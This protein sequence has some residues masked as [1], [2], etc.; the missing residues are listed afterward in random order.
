VGNRRALIALAAAGL[1]AATGLVDAARAVKPGTPGRIAFLTGTGDIA[2]VAG[3]GSGAVHVL[4]STGDYNS[5]PSWSP[6]GRAMVAHRHDAVAG[7]VDGLWVI[8]I[9]EGINAGTP[10]QIYA[11]TFVVSQDPAWAPDGSRVAFT[12][13]TTD[14]VFAVDA[15]GGGG[16]TQ[17]AATLGGALADDPAWSPDGSQIAFVERA[18]GGVNPIEVQSVGAGFAT[19]VTALNA[20]VRNSPTWSPDGTRIAFDQGPGGSLSYITLGNQSETLVLSGATNPAWSPDGSRFAA[21]DGGQIVTTPIGGGTLTILSDIPAG[22]T[23]PDWE[24]VAAPPPPPPPPPQVGP[25][26]SL[27][28]AGINFGDQK[29]G[30]KSEK[31]FVTLRNTGG[32]TLKISK[33][34]VSGD[35]AI[36]S[37]TNTCPAKLTP[38]SSCEFGATFKPKSKGRRWG[39]V[40]VF[41]DAPDS[42]Q[43]V[44]LTGKGKKK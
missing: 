8:P 23:Q 28:P 29:V 22:S 9:L 25:E 31:Q 20:E 6:D 19:A 24:S 39:V 11:D 40:K 15:G 35:F 17:I 42:P 30:K 27:S 43:R 1:L 2:F 41:D 7:G 21:D 12:S 44:E 36:S 34:Y 10:F 14:G 26:V 4:T 38:G 33:I 13:G 32:A 16:L 5:G 37:S 18:G 3:D